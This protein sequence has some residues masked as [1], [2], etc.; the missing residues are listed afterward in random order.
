MLIPIYQI[1]LQMIALHQLHGNVT[2]FFCDCAAALIIS[3]SIFNKRYITLLCA[4][5][6][7]GGTYVIIRRAVLRDFRR[8]QYLKVLITFLEMVTVLLTLINSTAVIISLI[9]LT[10]VCQLVHSCLL[11]FPMHH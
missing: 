5:D 3:L 7:R 9:I 1:W 11:A 10:V 2:E 8:L 6:L 4:F